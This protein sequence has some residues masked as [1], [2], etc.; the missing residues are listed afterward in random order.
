M[1]KFSKIIFIRLN[2]RCQLSVQRSKMTFFDDFASLLLFHLLPLFFFPKTLKFSL[3]FILTFD[4]YC[5]TPV[6]R[7][8]R[9][10]WWT[11]TTIHFSP[12]PSTLLSPLPLLYLSSSLIS[13]ISLSKYM[14]IDIP[15]SYLHQ[16]QI[17]LT[18]LRTD[19]CMHIYILYSGLWI[20]EWCSIWI[21]VPLSL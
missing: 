6:N 7:H 4:L 14:Y 21:Y 3:R 19:I 11:A 16:N 8:C 12:P 15:K 9:C 10:W 18:K 20:W 2:S 1:N 5:E 13:S 17:K